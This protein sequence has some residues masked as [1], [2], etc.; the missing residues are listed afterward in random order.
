MAAP[1]CLQAASRQA[2]LHGYSLTVQVGGCSVFQQ[3][4]TDLKPGYFA[5][6][7]AEVRAAAGGGAHPNLAAE[8]RLP[9]HV[10]AL[11]AKQHEQ[12]HVSFHG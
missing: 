6:L 7:A 2:S 5:A 4:H 10:P 12:R 11:A 8:C 1:W 3:L 9:A